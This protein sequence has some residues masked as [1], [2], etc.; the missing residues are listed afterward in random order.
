[1]KYA[2]ITGGGTGLG[3]ALTLMLSLEPEM[4]VLITGRTDS[5]LEETQ[6][7]NPQKIMRVVAD[8]GTE[9]GREAVFNALPT[10]ADI[11]YLVH[12][13]ASLAPKRLVDI[14]LSEFREQ[15]ATNL[16]APIFLTQ[17]L[18]PY[19]HTGSRVLNISSGYA[20]KPGNGVSAFSI[21]KAALFMA[22]QCLAQELK[23]MGIHVGSLRP[24]LIDTNAQKILRETPPAVF[25]EQPTFVAFQQ[26]GKLQPPLKPAAFAKWVLINTDAETFSASEW[27]IYDEWHQAKWA[28]SA[29]ADEEF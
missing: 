6:N 21:G 25:P 17:K 20:H 4:M 18:L 13:A 2:V 27:N 22:Y 28:E 3:R 24:G 1:M 11:A 26:E 7:I 29:P 8:I 23:G 12:C 19:L 14:T 16:E 5:T 10:D 9:G 15:M